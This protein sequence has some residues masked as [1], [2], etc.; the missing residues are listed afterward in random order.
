MF[1]DAI[2]GIEK[3]FQSEPPEGSVILI[4]GNAGT[5]KSAFTYNLISNNMARRPNDLAQC[6]YVTLEETRESLLRNIKTM[7]IP[8]SERIQ[9]SDVASFLSA[10]DSW[11]PFYILFF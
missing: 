3:V 8:V 11:T 4:V 2:P 6:I 7:G 5:L 9:I 10:M 1:I